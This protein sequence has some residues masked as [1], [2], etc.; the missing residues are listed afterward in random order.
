MFRGFRGL[1]LPMPSGPPFAP[2][3]DGRCLAAP[4]PARAGTEF[5]RQLP[6]TYCLEHLGGSPRSA[7]GAGRPGGARGPARGRP[8]AKGPPRRARGVQHEF[9]E[10]CTK[11]VK[12][13]AAQTAAPGTPPSP[14]RV[15]ATGGPLAASR[16]GA[17]SPTRRG[18]RRGGRGQAWAASAQAVLG[19]KLMVALPPLP[20]RPPLAAAAPPPKVFESVSNT[21]ASE[22]PAAGTSISAARQVWKLKAKTQPPRV[23]ARVLASSSTLS[24]SC[25]GAEFHLQELAA[26][27]RLASKASSWLNLRSVLSASSYLTREHSSLNPLPARGMSTGSICP[28]SVPIQVIV[29]SPPMEA[30]SNFINFR[31]AMPRLAC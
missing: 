12:I 13:M 9:W 28:N 31:R 23:K 30:T 29:A 26:L 14:E 6:R 18:M 16:P 10:K 2:E 25:F 24:T 15:V 19:A 7:R 5:G 8:R 3:F 21:Q 20:G 11:H 27:F 17:R 4:G 22:P 1:R